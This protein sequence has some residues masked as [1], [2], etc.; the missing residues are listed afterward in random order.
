[1]YFDHIFP[2]TPLTLLHRLPTSCNLYFPFLLDPLSPVSAA[3]IHMSTGPPT[4]PLK[5]K[6]FPFSISHQL[7][8]T[9]HL[10]RG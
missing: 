10:G 1:M 5:K 9:A 4:M 3:H 8:V 7:P 6:D 2:P